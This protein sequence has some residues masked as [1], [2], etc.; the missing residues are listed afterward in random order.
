MIDIDLFNGYNDSFGH[1]AGDDCLR[2]V[3]AGLTEALKRPDDFLA[4]YG[5]EDF[6]AILPP[7]DM[8]GA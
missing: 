2:R 8:A 1:P 6:A 5:G 3:V 7:T 4:R